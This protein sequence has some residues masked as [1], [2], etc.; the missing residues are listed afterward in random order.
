[1]RRAPLMSLTVLALGLAASAA[2]AGPIFLPGSLRGDSLVPTP[3]EAQPFR[4]RYST[5]TGD[6][7]GGTAR[8]V[9]TDV[10]TGPAEPIDAVAL[11]PLPKGTAADAVQV[12]LDGQPAEGRFLDAATAGDRYADFAAASKQAGLVALTGQPAWLIPKVRLGAKHTVAVTLTAPATAPAAGFARVLSPLPSGT[13][14]SAP[15][16]RITVDLTVTGQAPVR[17]IISPSHEVDVTRLSPNQARVRATLQGLADGP[18][19]FEL[20]WAEDADPVGLRVITHRAEGEDDGYFLVLGHPTGGGTGEAPPKDVVFVLD[21]SGSMRGAKMEQARDAITWALGKLA[22]EDRFNVITFGTEVRRFA[23]GPVAADAAARAKATDFVDETLAMGRTNIADAL[24]AAVAGDRDP[25][26]LRVVLFLTDGSPTAGEVEPE[27]ILKALPQT[28]Q[29]G[30]ARIFA[31]GVGHDVNTWLLDQMAARSGGRSVFVGPDEAIDA[32]IASLYESLQH[33]LADAIALDFGGLKVDKVHPTSL[34]ALFQGQE[35]L[36][37]G[38]YSGGGRHTVRLKGRLGKADRAWSTTLEFPAKAD[39]ADA[40]VASLWAARRIGALLR[41]LRL[42]G[43]DDALVKEVIE[44]SRRFGIVTEYTA[45]IA[46][47]GGDVDGAAIADTLTRVREANQ[48]R[49]GSWA[50]NQA[51][52]EKALIGRKASTSTANYYRDRQGK[53]KRAEV[54]T[55]GRK[56]FYKKDDKWVQADAPAAAAPANKRRVKRFSPEYFELVKKS[57]DFA[58]AQKLDAPVEMTVADEQVEV[59]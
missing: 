7:A 24:A 56:A 58:E 26:R 38:R 40:F 59:Y 14:G 44:L 25:E 1:M 50:F 4:A 52:N 41:D 11:L 55:V 32:T 10:V 9:I 43:H 53:R 33:P 22:P 45:F 18:D 47:A 13:F 46:Q 5:T 54:K 27:K 20:L 16:E 51:A 37:S 35:V 57:P 3:T 30:D 42:E 19:A 15:P 34:G 6:I 48:Q 39:P 31:L 23:D 36:V 29:A 17:G 12:T 21:T 8:L 28:A 2:Q 49:S